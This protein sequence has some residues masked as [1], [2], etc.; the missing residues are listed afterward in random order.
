MIL[1]VLGRRDNSC[2]GH[3]LNHRARNEARVVTIETIRLSCASTPSGP[4]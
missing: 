2:G 1:T 4:A 3:A